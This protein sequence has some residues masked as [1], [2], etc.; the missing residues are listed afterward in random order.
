MLSSNFLKTSSNLLSGSHT[1]LNR[2]L[3]ASSAQSR[4]F[5][6]AFNIKSKFEE[7]F[8]KKRHSQTN[9]PK[10]EYY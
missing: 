9:Q 1:F 7:A 10:K 2:V 4:S 6:V 3:V 5:S 8:E